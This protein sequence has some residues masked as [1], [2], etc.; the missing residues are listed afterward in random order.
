MLD[1][2]LLVDAGRSRVYCAPADRIPSV[3]EELGRLREIA[4]RAAGAES[5]FARPA[6]FAC[7][8]L[9]VAAFD[10]VDLLVTPLRASR[11]AGS[12]R[13][14]MTQGDRRILEEGHRTSRP[15]SSR[16]S[17]WNSSSDPQMTRR[18]ASACV[19]NVRR[20]SDR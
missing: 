1:D 3:L 15:N 4:F 16:A 5:A 17:R 8:Y 14:E 7:H 18:D 11:V 13:V 10:A 2:A 12:Y 6:S 19:R 20:T 9:S